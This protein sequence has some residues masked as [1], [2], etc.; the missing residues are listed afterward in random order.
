M[1][2]CFLVPGSA[3]LAA[4]VTWALTTWQQGPLDSYVMT[5]EQRAE[6][7]SV[8]VCPGTWFLRRVPTCTI[9]SQRPHLPAL[10][11]PR[12]H[13]LSLRIPAAETVCGMRG[14][15][16]LDLPILRKL[17]RQIAGP[18]RIQSRIPRMPCGSV[19]ET[20]HRFGP[21]RC[22]PSSTQQIGSCLP[23]FRN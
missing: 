11:T 15:I 13:H 6:E 14:R 10:P 3:R 1:E 4:L 18:T 8:S 19:G 9:G 2:M 16:G 17:R 23:H 5:A 12:T 20:Q 21:T 7:H 22:G